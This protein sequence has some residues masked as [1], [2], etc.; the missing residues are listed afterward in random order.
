VLISR[1]CQIERYTNYLNTPESTISCC[2][3]LGQVKGDGE[4]SCFTQVEDTCIPVLQDWCHKITGSSRERSARNFLTH[5]KIFSNSVRA[6]IEGF[7]EVT[8]TDR[9]TLRAKWESF[10]PNVDD[11]GHHDWFV[12]DLP[13]PLMD[14]LYSMQMN[15]RAPKVDPYGEPIGVTPRLV[16]VCPPLVFYICRLLG[17]FIGFCKCH[18]KLCK[19]APG[20]VP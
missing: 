4:P 17:F 7:S 20:T 6:Y 12:P 9:A 16:K 1:L 13:D 8:E 19:R 10:D 5:I 18:Q 14:E 2:I 3:S 11:G 15:T